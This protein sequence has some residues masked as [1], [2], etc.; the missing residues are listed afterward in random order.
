M[1]I[2]VELSKSVGISLSQFVLL[3]IISSVKLPAP[4]LALAYSLNLMTS[5]IFEVSG[6]VMILLPSVI[7]V[8][9]VAATPFKV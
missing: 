2:I 9:K 5:E 4:P 3:I 8:I 6:I 1:I 7:Y